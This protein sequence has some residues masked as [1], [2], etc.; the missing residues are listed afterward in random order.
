[1]LSYSVPPHQTLQMPALSPSMTQGNIIAWNVKEG[2][3]V[4][5][6]Q[7]LAEV[8]TDKASMAWEATD[9]GYVAKILVAAGSEGIKVG[10]VC[11]CVCAHV[12]RRIGSALERADRTWQACS[13]D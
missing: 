5:A 4:S 2:D 1:M 10:T 7:V 13:R 12:L 9:D 3:Q 6:G 11:V 8:E